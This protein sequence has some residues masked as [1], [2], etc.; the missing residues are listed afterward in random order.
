MGFLEILLMVLLVG[1]VAVLVA[2][3]LTMGSDNEKTKHLNNLLMRYRVILQ[4]G[5]V[6]LLALLIYLSQSA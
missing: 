5:A 3:M 4:G 2:G 6:A 1:V